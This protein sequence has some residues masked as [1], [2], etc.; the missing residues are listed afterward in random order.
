[1]V[2]LALA[3]ATA[4]ALTF[5]LALARSLG[6]LDSLFVFIRSRSRIPLFL[7]NPATLLIPDIPD[8]TVVAMRAMNCVRPGKLTA[9]T[10]ATAMTIIPIAS[11]GWHWLR[12]WIRPAEKSNILEEVVLLVHRDAVEEAI[13]FMP[14]LTSR[15][16]SH[17]RVGL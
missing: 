13:S 7:G 16:A 3:F 11:L 1:L 10:A 15:R 14:R 9:R 5:A 8:L 17:Q 6:C 12:V 2:A 4:L